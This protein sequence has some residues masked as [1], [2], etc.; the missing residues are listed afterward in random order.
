MILWKYLNLWIKVESET[1]KNNGK[2]QKH[3]FF[4]MFLVTLGPILLFSLL[5][6]KGVNWLNTPRYKANI[7]GRSW[8]GKN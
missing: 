6:G 5:K 3:G 8:Y 2:K 4:G 1:V 7:L